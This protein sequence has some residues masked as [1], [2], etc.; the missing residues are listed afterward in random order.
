L[1]QRVPR[2]HTSGTCPVE[3]QS[4]VGAVLW[5]I[6]PLPRHPGYTRGMDIVLIVMG[7]PGIAFAAFCLWLG[8][9]VI[10]RRE[11][12]AKWTAAV[13]V[14]LARPFIYCPVARLEDQG[15]IAPRVVSVD[16]ES[17]IWI[18][19]ITLEAIAGPFRSYNMRCIMGLRDTIGRGG[20]PRD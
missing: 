19:R 13:T 20:S 2:Q 18:L 9:R 17:L 16:Y 11:R 15:R 14:L 1:L 6:F 4:R 5:S 3:S 8:V 12:W 10:N 7:V